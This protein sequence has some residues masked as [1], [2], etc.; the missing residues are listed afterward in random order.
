MFSVDIFRQ[1]ADGSTDSAKVA[2]TFMNERFES[3]KKKEMVSPE[4]N[5]WSVQLTKMTDAGLSEEEW[6]LMADD[7]LHHYHREATVSRPPLPPSGYR[8]SFQMEED[9]RKKR[10]DNL[11]LLDHPEDLA[12]RI[13]K[14]SAE[15]KKHREGKKAAR[16]LGVSV[17]N[18]TD[19][20]RLASILNLSEVQR[21]L[22]EVEA[23][24]TSHE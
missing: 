24:G 4:Q 18:P 2:I 1:A 13:H 23:R 17:M 7:V 15:F 12:A 9:E 5:I 6:E 8:D 11:N 10:E 16:D 22:L 3:F 19:A 21:H 20:S 14:I